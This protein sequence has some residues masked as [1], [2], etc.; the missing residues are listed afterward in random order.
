MC[1]PAPSIRSERLIFF[2]Y[3]LST[4]AIYWFIKCV[5]NIFSLF[6]EKLAVKCLPHRNSRNSCVAFCAL[7][8]TVKREKKRLNEIWRKLVHLDCT[9][10]CSHVCDECEFNQ[11]IVQSCVAFACVRVALRTANKRNKTRVSAVAF[12]PLISARR[13]EPINC[14]NTRN[15][16]SC[17]QT[18]S[19]RL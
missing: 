3:Q 9:A 13:H 5:I 19:I 6:D 17:Q 10:G 14:R 7:Q 2:V 15:S 8:M 11:M 18:S 4:S 12:L 1:W 16:W